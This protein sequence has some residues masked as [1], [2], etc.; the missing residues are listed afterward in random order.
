MAKPRVG[1]RIISKRNDGQY[2]VLEVTDQRRPVQDGVASLE[3]ARRVARDGLVEG[4]RLWYRDH[5]DAPE[6]L[7]EL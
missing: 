6:H 1:D 5:R 4:G 7:E 2:D 3:A